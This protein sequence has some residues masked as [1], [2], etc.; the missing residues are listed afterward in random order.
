MLKKLSFIDE[1]VFNCFKQ[2]GNHEELVN[3]VESHEHDTHI[4]ST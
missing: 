2:T 1:Y 4:D 3:Y